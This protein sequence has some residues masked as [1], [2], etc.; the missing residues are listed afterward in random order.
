[1]YSARNKKNEGGGISLFSR[2]IRESFPSAYTWIHES[3]SVGRQRAQIRGSCI[4]PP[5]FGESGS[6]RKPPTVE[7]EDYRGDGFTDKEFNSQQ[8]AATVK[9]Y[10]TEQQV[11][12]Y[13]IMSS[14]GQGIQD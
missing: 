14:R 7:G 2:R 4:T 12:R 11:T 9:E 8:S 13:I 6:I 10:K 5:P 1:M 3:A